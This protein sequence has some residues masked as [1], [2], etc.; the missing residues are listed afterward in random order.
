MILHLSSELNRMCNNI[1]VTLYLSG[2]NKGFDKKTWE[3]AGH[4]KDGDK[5][6][7]TFK[8]HSADGEEGC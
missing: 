8:Y 3:V 7:I 2:G 4:K 1:N 6:F 5:P